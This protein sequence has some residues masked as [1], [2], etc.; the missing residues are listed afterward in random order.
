MLPPQTADCQQAGADHHQQYSTFAKI[1]LNSSRAFVLLSADSGFKL[2]PFPSVQ[3]PAS[4]FLYMAGLTDRPEPKQHHRDHREDRKRCFTRDQTADLVDDH[5]DDVSE[6]ACSRSPRVSISVVHLPFDRAHRR[7]AWR[8]QQ[9]EDHET[10]RRQRAVKSAAISVQISLPASLQ[11]PAV[12]VKN[13]EG[14][15]NFFLGDQAGYRR[16]CRLSTPYRRPSRG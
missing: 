8:A 14:I 12:M 3:L 5:R 13:T 11:F 15:D 2:S 7:E 4:G 16:H 1:T 10:V 9:V 6:A